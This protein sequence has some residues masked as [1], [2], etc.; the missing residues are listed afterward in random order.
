MHKHKHSWKFHLSALL[1]FVLT[2]S[3]FGYA[4]YRTNVHEELEPTFGI[5]Y[6]WIYA[7]QLG[8][9]PID[10]Y[11]VLLEELGVTHVR[12][13]LYW[14]E[15]EHDEEQYNWEIPDELMR[16]SDQAGVQATVVVGAKVPRW[17]ECFIPDWAEKLNETH[18]HYGVLDYIEEAVTRYD[19]HESVIRW[20]VENEP[21][22]PFGECPEP[23]FGLFKERVDVTR[24]LTDK[25]IQ[26]TVSG[27]IGP[28]TDAAQAADI[29][30]LSMYRQTFNDAFG[31]FVYP[32]SP[33][34]YYFRAE[35]VRDDV[36][37]VI[38]SELQAEPWFSAP[39]DSKERTQ[40]YDSFTVEMFEQNIEFARDA[41]LSEAYLWG[42]E[43][44][45]ALKLEGDD[46]LWETARKLF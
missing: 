24:T 43:W 8:L 38:V 32:L 45:Y 41:M 20:Q 18:Q 23:N 9:D 15:I 25:P 12:L 7:E 29:L 14:S 19:A 33:S 21:F 28:W 42:A 10:T 27:E 11:Q 2:L 3:M 31:Y 40:W 36:Q 16:I 6:S 46:R 34:Y 1:V 39:I 30:G 26:V 13:P 35:L 4:F 17:P 37:K 5:T 44:W 22:F